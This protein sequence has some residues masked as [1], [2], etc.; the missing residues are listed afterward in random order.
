[1]FTRSKSEYLFAAESTP[2]N[3]PSSDMERERG[4]G[5]AKRVRYRLGE[6][7]AHR[8][9]VPEAHAE[10]PAREAPDPSE[11]LLGERLV[12]PEALPDA[13]GPSRG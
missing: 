11:V 4:D 7:I 3:I 1:M 12:E 5:E 10:I 8:P 2:R 9:L 13:A 6:E